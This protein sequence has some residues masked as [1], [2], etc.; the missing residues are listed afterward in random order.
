MANPAPQN[1]ANHVRHDT[2][3][4]FYGSLYIA[5][6]VTA[7][8]SLFA[9]EPSTWLAISLLCVATAGSIAAVNSRTYGLKMQNRIIR[10]EMR[11]RLAKL[12]DPELSARIPEL[13]IGQLAALRFASDAELP[14]LTQKVLERQL[15][16]GKAIKQSVTDWQ[17]DHLRV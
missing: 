7:L 14:A 8:V 13:T 3:L 5:G 17:A 4:Y 11:L 10:L 2:L 12:L 1:Y 9:A 15:T 16:D 6:L